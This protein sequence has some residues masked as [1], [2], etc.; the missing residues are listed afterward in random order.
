MNFPPITSSSEA[1][2][3]FHKHQE[4]SLAQLPPEMIGAILQMASVTD[5]LALSLTSRT[6]HQ[7]MQQFPASPQD[8]LCACTHHQVIRQIRWSPSFK[9]SVVD[10][11]FFRDQRLYALLRNGELF[12]YD[13]ATKKSTSLFIGRAIPLGN[14]FYYDHNGLFRYDPVANQF[15]A[16]RAA[17]GDLFF[18][19][20]IPKS[21]VSACQDF[22]ALVSD[23]GELLIFKGQDV[24]V[25]IQPSATFSESKSLAFTGHRVVHIVNQSAEFYVYDIDR[26][27]HCIHLNAEAHAMAT[28]K[29]QIAILLKDSSVV[30]YNAATLENEFELDEKIPGEGPPRIFQFKEGK[31]YIAIDRTLQVWNRSTKEKQFLLNAIP[32][33]FAID[34]GLLAMAVENGIDLWDLEKGILLE[35]SILPRRLRLLSIGSIMGFWD[36][37][38]DL[39]TVGSECGVRE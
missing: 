33:V 5:Q 38:Q 17:F 37:L 6:W 21:A 1:A 12:C 27:K 16:V 23:K 9:S 39:R 11:T 26:T 32:Y 7:I 29:N 15:P 30:I 19:G 25:H 18:W 36:W 4:K 14:N 13:L 24:M 31:L 34:Q 8:A 22:A 28:N 20:T 2:I 10:R 3:S 35:H